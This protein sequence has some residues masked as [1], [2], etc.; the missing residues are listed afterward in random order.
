MIFFRILIIFSLFFTFIKA[1]TIIKPQQIINTSGGVTDIVIKKDKLYA[2]TVNGTIDI[3]DLKT[4]KLLD[5]IY[6]PKTIDFVGDKI[7]A[8]IYSVDVLNDKILILSQ[9]KKGGRNIFL[10]ENHKLS[11]IIDETKRLFISKAKF[12]SKDKIVYSLLSNQF[13][14]FNLSTKENIYERQI[15]QSRFSDF[16]LNDDKSKIILADESGVLHEY[17]IS[18]GK[19]I[20]DFRNQNLDN[21]YQ[22]DWKKDTIITAGQDRR[23]VVY[24]ETTQSAYYKK[25]DFLVYSCGLSPNSHYAGY[26]SDELNTVTV[27]NTLTQT[28]MYKL[29]DNKM[30]ITNIVFLNDN[31]IFVSSDDSKINYYKIK[32]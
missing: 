8:K 1:S 15:S 10:Y 18:N 14:L 17:Q 20:R 7:D 27:F 4:K 13:F 26:S 25:S 28:S 23:S 16:S 11:K 22:V 21:V 2:S 12:I 19:F 3:F 32:D 6:V 30:I 24:N 9:G 5:K 29:V 31:E